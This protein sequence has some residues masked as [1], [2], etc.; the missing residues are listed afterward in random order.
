MVGLL[1]AAPVTKEFI[2][3]RPEAGFVE[4][5]RPHGETQDAI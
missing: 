2:N 3:Q 1:T 4:E 5:W